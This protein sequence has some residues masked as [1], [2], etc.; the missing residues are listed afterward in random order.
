MTVIKLCQ[1]RQTQSVTKFKHV[2]ALNTG[3]FEDFRK[4]FAR[5][6]GRHVMMVHED[7]ASGLERHNN[8]E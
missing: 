4:H 7:T 6:R 2:K 3:I 5:N 8:V 1:A